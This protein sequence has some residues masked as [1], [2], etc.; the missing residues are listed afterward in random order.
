MLGCL[1]DKHNNISYKNMTF[2][3]I[4]VIRVNSF[5][6][7]LCVEYNCNVNMMKYLGSFM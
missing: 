7:I 1:C 5:F 2:Y 3:D 6:S 4:T